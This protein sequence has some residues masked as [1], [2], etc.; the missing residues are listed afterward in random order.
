MFEK[1]PFH[2][3]VL[4]ERRAVV[5]M[6]VALAASDD[7]FRIDGQDQFSETPHTRSIERAGGTPAPVER[8]AIDRCG[9]GFQV[10][11]DVERSAAIAAITQIEARVRRVAIDTNQFERE[12]HDTRAPGQSAAET[13]AEDSRPASPKAAR[14]AAATPAVRSR[15]GH[16]AKIEGPA[17]LIDAAVAPAARAASRTASQPGISALRAGVTI[18]SSNARPSSSRSS[19]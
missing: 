4:S 12:A 14:I 9:N 15:D 11:D 1:D 16:N 17:P 6:R 8:V 18:L 13:T 7:V 5:E 10:V 3:G 19:L 2:S